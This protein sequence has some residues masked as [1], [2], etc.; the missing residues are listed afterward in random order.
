MLEAN[1]YG[2]GGCA[3][4]IMPIYARRERKADGSL[5]QADVMAQE[6]SRELTN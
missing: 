4:E 2:Q 5:T 3:A 6:V 1:C